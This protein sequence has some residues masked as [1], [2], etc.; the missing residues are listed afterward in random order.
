[1]KRLFVVFALFAGLTALVKAGG[2]QGQGW[3]VTVVT[4]THTTIFEGRGYLRKIALSSGTVTGTGEWLVAMST[5][6]LGNGPQLMPGPLA[7]STGAV[8]PPL[9][10]YSTNTLTFTG[11]SL[12]NSWSIGDCDTCFVEIPGDG[13]LI[14]RKSAE[15]SGAANIATVYWSK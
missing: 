4:G 5:Y 12:N 8:T 9:V 3:D 15:S 6:G 7:Q 1:M 2:R 13:G 10:F 11:A 14:I